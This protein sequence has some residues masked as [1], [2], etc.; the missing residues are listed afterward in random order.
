M[1]PRSVFI[2]PISFEMDAHISSFVYIYVYLYL[3]L[4]SCIF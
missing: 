2:I 3:L 4:S 1:D